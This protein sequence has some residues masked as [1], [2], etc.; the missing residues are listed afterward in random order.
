MREEMDGLERDFAADD[1]KVS[2]DMN[3]DVRFKD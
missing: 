2:D 3:D 1:R